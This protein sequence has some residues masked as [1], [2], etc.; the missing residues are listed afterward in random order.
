MMDE[1]TSKQ[2]IW[3]RSFL[4]RT[5]MKLPCDAIEN[6]RLHDEFYL[7]TTGRNATYEYPIHKLSFQ[8]NDNLFTFIYNEDR[9]AQ[10]PKSLFVVERPGKPDYHLTLEEF[11][12]LSSGHKYQ[13]VQVNNDAEKSFLKRENKTEFQSETGLELEISKISFIKSSHNLVAYFYEIRCE[14]CTGRAFLSFY[15]NDTRKF[16]FETK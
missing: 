11:N 1:T 16:L 8:I 3:D 15:E 7:I 4:D 6:V 10:N 12:I 9:R 14:C 5:S 2:M 13:D